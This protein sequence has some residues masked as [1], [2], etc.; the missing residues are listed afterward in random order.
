MH[1]LLPGLQTWSAPQL[2]SLSQLVAGAI[3]LP[4][5]ATQMVWAQLL[6]KRKRRAPGGSG[7]PVVS[8]V[9]VSVVVPGSP[10]VVAGS[11]V[12]VGAAV[13]G[14]AVDEV[15]VVVVDEEGLV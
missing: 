6:M 10:V 1:S 7:A 14:A 3:G 11:L 2:S 9:L 4:I 13:V 5:E 8:L 15:G 12:V